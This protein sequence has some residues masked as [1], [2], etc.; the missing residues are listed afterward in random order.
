MSTKSNE[1]HFS[2]I[3]GDYKIQL[4]FIFNDFKNKWNINIF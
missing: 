3:Q 4:G 2:T 1:T